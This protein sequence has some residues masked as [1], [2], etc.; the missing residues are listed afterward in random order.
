MN[1]QHITD[2]IDAVADTGLA[3]LQLTA[4]DFDLHIVRNAEGGGTAALA[5]TPAPAPAASRPTPPAVASVAA[6]SPAAP[7]APEGHVIHAPMVGTFY[8]ASARGADALVQVGSVVAAGAAVC[9][10]ES[11]KIFNEIDSEH[12]GTVT[13][14]LCEDGQAVSVGQALMVIA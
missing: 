10:I 9:V 8:R 11:M 5:A 2:L 7:A 4:P 3:E 12:A 13:A 6:P 14:V 1:V